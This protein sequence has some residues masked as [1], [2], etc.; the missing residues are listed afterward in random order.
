M[1]LTKRFCLK[2]NATTEVVWKHCLVKHSTRRGIERCL[3]LSHS[4]RSLEREWMRG[5]R[6]LPHYEVSLLSRGLFRALFFLLFNITS[7]DWWS[8]NG[9]L[10]SPSSESHEQ[11]RNTMGF[12]TVNCNG[13]STAVKVQSVRVSHY[14]LPAPRKLVSMRFTAP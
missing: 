8:S 3:V 6:N 5:L 11:S 9:Y 14:P 7:W 10:F 13:R 4:F 1:R 12:G 2:F